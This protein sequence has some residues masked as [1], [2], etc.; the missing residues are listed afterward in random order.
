MLNVDLASF[1]SSFAAFVILLRVLADV[2]KEM[3][4]AIYCTGVYSVL[5]SGERF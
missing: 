2:K 3:Q 1:S 4:S 5:M